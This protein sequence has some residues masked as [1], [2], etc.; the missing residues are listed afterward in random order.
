MGQYKLVILF[1]PQIGLIIRYQRGVSIE[2]GLP[3]IQIN[4]G[5]TEI[6]QGSNIFGKERS[7]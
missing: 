2:I 4:F 5:L 3:L 7:K 1:Q 6:A